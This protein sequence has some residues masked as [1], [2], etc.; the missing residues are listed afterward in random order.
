MSVI[1]TLGSMSNHGGTIITAT[2][3]SI[4]NGVPVAKNGDFHACPIR[5][6]GTTPVFG[7]SNVLAQGV[8]VL[9]T[10]AVAGCGA[11]IITGQPN[12]LVEI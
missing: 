1:V 4:A 5:G 10:G 11:I 7:G 8:P 12:V 6:H 2:T 9:S 3:N